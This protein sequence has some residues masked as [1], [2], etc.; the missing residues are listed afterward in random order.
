MPGDH[1][2]EYASPWAGANV[3]PMSAEGSEVSNY[4]RRSWLHLE[5]LCRENPETGIHFQGK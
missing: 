2:I 5:R 1:D 3:M 4:E